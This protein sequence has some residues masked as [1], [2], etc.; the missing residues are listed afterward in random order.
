MILLFVK[1]LLLKKRSVPNKL[2]INKVVNKVEGSRV[3]IFNKEN[4]FCKF[5]WGYM[6]C[7]NLL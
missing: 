2:L 6:N 7:S 1:K 5:T 4:F 3:N